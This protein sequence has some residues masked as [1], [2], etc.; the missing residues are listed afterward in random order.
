[1]LAVR[2]ASKHHT[3][4]LFEI[5][6]KVEPALTALSGTH[7]IQN[8]NIFSPSS[9]SSAESSALCFSKR[10]RI[11]Y[12]VSLVQQPSGLSPAVLS[13]SQ[14]P[15]FQDL[16]PEFVQTLSKANLEVKVTHS[17]TLITV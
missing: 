2:I 7:C 15:S 13:I 10:L 8:L 6:K 9:S 14:L 3:C 11:P 5:E 12:C 17:G 1:M 16:H 4:T